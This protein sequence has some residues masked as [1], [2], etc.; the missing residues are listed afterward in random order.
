MLISEVKIQLIK[1]QGGLIAFVSLVVGG[2]LYLS[3]I[4]IHRKLDGCGHRLTYQ[5]LIDRETFDACQQV[6]ARAATPQQAVRET[7]EDFVLRGL[8]TC[9]TSGRKATCDIKKGRYVYL[10]VRD[11]EQ[12]ERKLWVKESVVL[13]QIREV[14]ESIRIPNDVLAE[15]IGYLNKSHDAEKAFHRERIRTLQKE[16]AEVTRRLDRLTDLILDRSITKDIYDR[17]H[18]EL[19][20][21]SMTGNTGS[22]RSAALRPEAFRN[23]V[24]FLGVLIRIN[25]REQLV[26]TA[27]GR[28][29]SGRRPRHADQ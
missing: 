12:P 28:K 22:C 25:D 1:P 3:G 26:P 24:G 8:V 4:G 27:T 11:P 7:K 2:K 20:R 5:T 21:T 16:S 14:M 9:A 10:I 6:R 13:D 23:L 15:M 19:Q 18:R 29:V 17:K